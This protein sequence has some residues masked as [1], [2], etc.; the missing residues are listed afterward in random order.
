MSNYESKKLIPMP[1]PKPYHK[2]TDK[3]LQNLL[4]S[5]INYN[6]LIPVLIEINLRQN[7]EIL[8]LKKRIS[9]LETKTLKKPGR[10]RTTY[11]LHGKELTDEELI[12]YIIMEKLNT[13]NIQSIIISQFVEAFRHCWF[14]QYRDE[15]EPYRNLNYEDLKTLLINPN[16]HSIEIVKDYMASYVNS[17]NKEIILS[18]Y[19]ETCKAFQELYLIAP[20]A[21]IDFNEG[22]IGFTKNGTLKYFD[23]Q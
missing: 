1:E 5:N 20:D 3:E 13:D 21:K 16:N 8:S 6:V 15:Y 23:L 10:K 22:N 11:Y 14:T 4:K 19:Q 17:E 18:L 7:M 12:Y 2:M 9:T